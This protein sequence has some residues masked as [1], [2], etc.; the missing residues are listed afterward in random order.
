MELLALLFTSPGPVIFQLGPLTLRW[1]GVL[2]TSGIILGT[3]MA[4]AL[5]SRRG[6]DPERI[7][8]LAVWAVV[9]GIPMARLYYV[10]FRWDLFQ[11]NP[12]GIFAIWEGGIAIH[13]GVLGGLLA[14]YFFTR[15]HQLNFWTVADAVAP[16][17]ALGQA[18][19]RWGNFFN[20]EAFGDPTDLPWKLYIPPAARPPSLAEFEFFHPTFL[21]E[22]FWDLGLMGLLLLVFTRWTKAKPGTVAALYALGY[23]LGRLWI[24][25]LRT[26]SLMLG[27][28][29][30]A[31]GVSLA[32]ITLGLFGLWWFNWRRTAA[33]EA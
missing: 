26:D 4:Q 7:A 20:S 17:L 8:D 29:R 30:I 28:L 24:E 12:W 23:S 2:V 11:N 21:Y 10:L 1:Y 33:N 9:L 22:S 15:R 3:F 6:I 18:V 13:G 27:P 19:G 14:G 25:G 16:G 5:A 32:G 31:Q